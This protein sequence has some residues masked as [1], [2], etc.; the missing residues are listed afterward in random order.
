MSQDPARKDPNTPDEAVATGA[1]STA[2][3]PK[4]DP[5]GQPTTDNQ[6]M[7]VEASPAS[8][9][10]DADDPDSGEARATLAAMSDP[11]VPVVE[12]AHDMTGV[13]IIDPVWVHSGYW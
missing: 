8:D 10:S 2:V 7:Q 12:P 6:R 11:S 13:Q 5:A 9:F 4:D 3:G 1:E